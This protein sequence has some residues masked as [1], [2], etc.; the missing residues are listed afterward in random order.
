M[1]RGPVLIDLD[2][3]DAAAPDRAP[4]VPETDAPGEADGRAMRRAMAGLARRPSWLARAFWGLVLTLLGVALSVAAWDF[5]TG[6]MTRA[7]LL[8]SMVAGLCG[9]LLVVAVLIALREAAG[10][11]RLGRLDALRSA[12]DAARTEADLDAAR[13]VVTRLRQLYA[14]RPEAAWGLARLDERAAD[15]FDAEGALSLAEAELLAPLDAA[16]LRE[17]EMARGRWRR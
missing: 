11:A 2:A 5:A 3:D 10:F 17:V 7:P 1:S 13:A 16:A 15:Q 14:K 6:L 8:G 12:A 4:P 9:L